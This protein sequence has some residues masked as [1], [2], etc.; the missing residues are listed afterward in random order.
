MR[1]TPGVRVDSRLER[2]PSS[3]ELSKEQ[4]D[5]FANE[6][7]GQYLQAHGIGK[8][9]VTGLDA[10]YCVNATVGGARNRGY[11]TTVVE[12]GIA[13]ESGKSL[14]KILEE[15]R[16]VGASVKNSGQLLTETLRPAAP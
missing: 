13:T 15:Y 5:A 6:E 11:D 14:L 12:D 10:N 2:P 16:K 3:V 8:L 1:G 7:L 9:I 4:G